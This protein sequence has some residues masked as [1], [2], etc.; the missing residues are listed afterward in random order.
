LFYSHHYPTNS[1]W[2]ILQTTDNLKRTNP[3]KEPS[4]ITQTQIAYTKAES[5][6]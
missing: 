3:E 6:K 1:L 2:L 5:S 4:L